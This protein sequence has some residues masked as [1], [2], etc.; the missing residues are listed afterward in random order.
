MEKCMVKA[1]ALDK[2][3]I[4][5][6]DGYSIYI[7]ALLSSDLSM[8]EYGQYVSSVDEL[9]KTDELVTFGGISTIELNYKKSPNRR[10]MHNQISEGATELISRMVMEELGLE[11]NHPDRY[12]EEVKIIGDLFS[13]IGNK[14]SITTY[15]TESYKI[16]RLLEQY[17]LRGKNLLHYISDFINSKGKSGSY[18]DLEDLNKAEEELE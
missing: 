8:Q 3:D 11:V 9:L 15:I 12:A 1:S 18:R 16:I 6:K 10:I 5:L 14:Y 7:N 17:R 2:R 4:V 13:S